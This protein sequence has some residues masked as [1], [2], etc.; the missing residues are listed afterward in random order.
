MFKAKNR[1]QLADFLKSNGVDAKIHYPIPMHLQPA[2][3]NLNYKYGD[4]PKAEYLAE[5]SISLPVHEYVNE[6][7]IHR[8]IELIKNF[9]K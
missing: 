4:F 1:D 6:D 2:A 7:Q 9:Y 8:M 5:N 3:K